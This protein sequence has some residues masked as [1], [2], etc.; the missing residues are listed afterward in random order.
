V[1]SQIAIRFGN[2]LV[3]ALAGYSELGGGRCRFDIDPDSV[4][5]WPLH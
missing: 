4:R 5:I 1:E 2:T 3:H